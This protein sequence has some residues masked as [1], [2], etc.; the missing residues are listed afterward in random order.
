VTDCIK[1]LENGKTE[2]YWHFQEAVFDEERVRH[3]FSKHFLFFTK[4]DVLYVISFVSRIKTVPV[5]GPE[6]YR[7]TFL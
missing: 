5:F 7:I 4:Q 2:F 3:V 6:K 1:G